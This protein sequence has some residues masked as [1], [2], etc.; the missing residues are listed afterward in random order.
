[1]TKSKAIETIK[2]LPDEFDLDT[3]V[4][5]LIFI[6]KIEQGLQQAKEGK[7]KSHEEVVKIVDKW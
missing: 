7:T 1:M 6:E 4:K 3:L 5:K 2:N